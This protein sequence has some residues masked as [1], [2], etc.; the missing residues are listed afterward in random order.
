[1]TSGSAV[2][3]SAAAAGF[4]FLD[5]LDRR[6]DQIRHPACT[7]TPAGSFRSLMC[8]TSSSFISATLYANHVGD[9][10]DQ[11]FDFQLVDDL[12][13]TPPSSSPLG[14]PLSSSGTVTSTFSSRL[15][16]GEID[17]NHFDAEVI[18]LHFLDQHLF[19]LAVDG[20]IEQMCAV[21]QMIRRLP[22][23]EA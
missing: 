1:M 4:L 5:F 12:L 7:C 3:P 17:V 8:R 11:A 10:G 16:A 18:V 13:S 21:V 22:S 2:S 14:S 6:D 9:F 19:A 20:Q 15:D 23:S